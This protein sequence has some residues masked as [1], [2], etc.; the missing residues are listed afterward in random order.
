M[1]IKRIR[2]YAVIEELEDTTNQILN[3]HT[4]E[5]AQCTS[6]EPLRAVEK[7]LRKTLATEPQKWGQHRR[8]EIVVLAIDPNEARPPFGTEIKVHDMIESATK[9]AQLLGVGLLTVHQMIYKARTLGRAASGAKI[10]GV[11]V[12]YADEALKI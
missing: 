6:E 5:L 4:R 3:S 9:A 12:A 7:L 1:L 10:R 8:K 2:I 11:T